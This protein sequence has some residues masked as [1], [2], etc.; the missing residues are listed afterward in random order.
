MVAAYIELPEY[1]K[2]RPME[3]Q[4]CSNLDAM[5]NP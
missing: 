1:K 4:C 2:D 3:L 5:L